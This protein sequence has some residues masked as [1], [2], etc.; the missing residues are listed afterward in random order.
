VS[1]DPAGRPSVP[2]GLIADLIAAFQA[3]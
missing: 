1:C 3:T 2:A